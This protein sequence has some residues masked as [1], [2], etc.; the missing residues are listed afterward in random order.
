[1]EAPL[2]GLA[3]LRS[4]TMRPCPWQSRGLS[5]RRALARSR[6][7]KRTRPQGASAD[8]HPPSASQTSAPSLPLWPWPEGPGPANTNEVYEADHEPDDPAIDDAWGCVNAAPISGRAS[9]RS[10]CWTAAC[11]RCRDLCVC[12]FGLVHCSARARG[13]RC[14]G[15]RWLVFCD[16]AVMSG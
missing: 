1:M 6:Y 13:R 16:F 8:L 5:L 14:A 12:V 10:E 2:A 11:Q 7:Q 3:G 15:L 4:T 9:A